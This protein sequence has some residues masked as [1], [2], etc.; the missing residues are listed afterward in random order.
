MKKTGQKQPRYLNEF[1][2]EQVEKRMATMA[3][4]TQITYE[5]ALENA[6]EVTRNSR[7]ADDVEL[8]SFA[9]RDLPTLTS[10]NYDAAVAKGVVLVYFC[11]SWSLTCKRQTP[12]LEQQV[13]PAVDGRATV[14]QVDTD[15][16]RALSFRVGAQFSVPVFLVFKDGREVERITG[17]HQGGL[18][19]KAIERAL[20]A[21]ASTDATT[22]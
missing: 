11:V 6:A 15:V 18:L 7:R 8:E 22:S 20:S 21:P 13:I 10:A 2:R 16:E 4:S 19:V 14:W 5:Q 12:I 3:K 9:A 17:F 1:H